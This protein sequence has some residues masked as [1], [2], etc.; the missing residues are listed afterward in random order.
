MFLA[1]WAAVLDNAIHNE[2]RGRA[3]SPSRSGS[4]R[5]SNAFHARRESEMSHRKA[6]E[7]IFAEKTKGKPYVFVVMSF[8]EKFALFKQIRTIVRDSV[9]LECFRADDFHASGVDLLS[10]MHILLERAELVIAEITRHSPNVF[11]EIG[12][13]VGAGKQVILM[14][15]EKSGEKVPIDFRGLELIQYEDTEPGLLVLD[16]DLRRHLRMRVKTNVA[17][18]RNMLEAEIPSPAYILASPKYPGAM[19][20]IQGQV[21]DTRTFGDNL[22]ILCLINAFGAFLGEAMG[23]ELISAQYHPPKLLEKNLNLYLIGSRKVN[24]AVEKLLPM[25]Q[26]GRR[27][28]WSFAPYPGQKEKGDWTVAL[29]RKVGKDKELI[30][31]YT[32]PR[33]KEKA[34]VW[35]ED[36]GLIVRGPHPRHSGRLVMI[37]AGSHSLGTGAACLAATRSPLIRQIKGKG[38]DIADKKLSFWA[39]VKGK[40]NTDDCLLDLKGVEVVEAGV[41]D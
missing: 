31:G 9:G 37:L 19:S 21:Y 23:V 12:Y 25:L 33:G 29:Y 30:E 14:V 7:N 11:Y 36:Y 24:P 40:A 39:L 27:P 2:W 8:G 34:D 17:E 1:P 13:A 26:R 35:M 16:T 38:I 6:I 18:L 15:E 3:L 28:E 32:E 22:G 41:Y 10:R 5:F 4:N 20:R